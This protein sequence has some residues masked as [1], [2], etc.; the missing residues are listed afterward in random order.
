MRF[1]LFG[2]AALT[3]LAVLPVTS[4]AVSQPPEEA[5]PA[6]RYTVKPGDTLIAIAQRYLAR[7]DAWPKVQKANRIVDP[8]RLQP[9]T[10]LRIPAV[11]LRKEPGA[12]RL[13]NVHGA[14]R[15]RAGDGPWQLATD[16]VQLGTGAALETLED[17]S[18]LLVLADGGRI[19]VSPGSQL[20]LDTLSLYAGGL[21]ADTRL[22]LK[23]GEADILANPEQRSQQNFRV[24][25]PSAQAVVRGTRFRVGT[26]AAATREE[27]LSGR[28]EVD[29]AGKS[30]SVPA[31][32]G[33][34]VRAGQAPLP[35]VALLPAADVS[36][37]P[38]RF[39]YLPLR[40]ELPR[41]DGVV[42]WQG[43]VAPDAEFRTILL[44]KNATAGHLSFADLPNGNYVLRLRGVD[45]VG[46]QGQDAQHH[47]TVFARPFPPGLNFPGDGATIRTARPRFA[48]GNIVGAGRYR[49]QVSADA[50][51]ASLLHDQ[52]TN[53]ENGE[54]GAD[55]PPGA[56]YWRAASLAESGEQ[57]P[58]SRPATF[59]YKPAPG[60]ADLGKAALQ[61]D[62]ER[63]VLALPSPPAGLRYEA[64]LA[65]SAEMQPALA[66]TQ[67]EDG[68][69]ELARPDSG[70]YYLGVRLVDSADGTPGP[71]AVQKIEVPPDGKLLLL[72]LP[73][74]LV[75]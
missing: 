56:L 13:Q 17:S 9:G 75:L 41:I 72:L 23:T 15:W 60:P 8:Y 51:F 68:R 31:E 27:T 70:T 12:A 49:Y 63:L 6:W 40:F 65:E 43:Q 4:F 58:W 44:S 22:H 46:L 20:V 42:A 1:A 5:T 47:F 2:G 74:L 39:E 19:V 25:T 3:F 29:A 52:T 55:L 36:N 48:W 59:V 26:D 62:G 37:L 61:I 14:V 30:V 71:E 33:T 38:R 35:P 34:M 69:L 73:L 7:S 21:M 57:G 50:D 67:A 45:T 10:V 11:M 28:V 24:R 32:Q 53:G 66:R 16:G 64:E 54:V 18:A